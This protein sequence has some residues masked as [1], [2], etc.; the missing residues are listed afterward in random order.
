MIFHQYKIALCTLYEFCAY[1]TLKP[2]SISNKA[3]GKR[4]KRHSCELAVSTWRQAGS[5]PLL[6]VFC[7][8]FQGRT[9]RHQWG[10][11]AVELER[12]VVG[13]RIKRQRV[14]S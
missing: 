5:F 8:V 13:C 7:R 12:V 6:G 14:E 4:L 3:E 10:T 9:L 2:Y 1:N 11:G